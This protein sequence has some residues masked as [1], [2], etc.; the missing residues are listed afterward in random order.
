MFHNIYWQDID[1]ELI[2][3]D[4]HNPELCLFSVW[5][6]KS[7]ST[8]QMYFVTD[9]ILVYDL[10]YRNKDSNVAQSSTGHSYTGQQILN[11]IQHYQPQNRIYAVGKRLG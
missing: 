4:P 2:A 6:Q 3:K 8:S 9:P 7:N 11:M 10:A 5:E 1:T